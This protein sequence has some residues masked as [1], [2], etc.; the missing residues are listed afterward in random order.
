MNHLFFILYKIFISCDI[1]KMLFNLVDGK[2][3][4]ADLVDKQNYTTENKKGE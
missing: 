2:L 1:R 3:M 4:I